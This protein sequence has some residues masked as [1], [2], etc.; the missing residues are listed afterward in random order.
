MKKFLSVLLA[1]LM[2]SAFAVIP[3]SAANAYTIEITNSADTVTVGDTI[4]V[5][6]TVSGVASGYNLSIVE[7]SLSYNAAYLEPAYDQSAAGDDTRF[8]ETPSGKAWDHITVSGDGEFYCFLSAD[9][10]GF[11]NGNVT[12]S[13]IGSG[14]T[15]TFVLP[16]TVLDAAAG[17]NV[18]ISLVDV[19]AFDAEDEDFTNALT[20]GIVNYSFTAAAKSSPITTIGAK[21]NTVTPALRLAAKYDATLLS[22]ARKDVEDIGI[23]FY[24]SRLLGDNEL[25]YDTTGALKL[26]AYG[27]DAE[28][29]VDGQ[30]FADYDS[31]VFYVTIVN[32]PA[33]GMDDMI[34]YRGY[35][36][37]YDRV[38][39]AITLAE[40]TNERSYN[41][42]YDLVY[43]SAGS[44]SGDN[45][46]YPGTGWFE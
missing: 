5:V 31:F 18:S 21:V 16:F 38:G 12:D 33:N 19:S 36:K 6:I 8:T 29:Y 15:L 25:T 35:I 34:S 22:V 7:F 39:G 1:V 24:P 32:I 13:A 28:D 9:D 43:P 10:T 2:L 44:G 30:E 4:D 27:I 42:V 23:V 3:A 41:Y 17:K 45:T 14:D 11:V 26:S 46:I 37:N 40:L 20:G